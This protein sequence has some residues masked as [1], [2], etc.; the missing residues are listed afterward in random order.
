MRYGSCAEW[1]YGKQRRDRLR[2]RNI[3]APAL[4][5]V[6]LGTAAHVFAADS[7]Y[8]LAKSDFKRQ[9]Q[10]ISLSPLTV[11]DLLTVSAPMRQLIEAEAAK[12]LEKTRFESLDI[13]PYAALRDTLATQIGGLLD[14]AGNIDPRRQRVVWDHAKREM[15][16]RYPMDAFA[17][18]SL[19]V[20]GAPF[21]DNKAGVGRHPPQRA[22][23]R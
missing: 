10:V 16:L 13:A 20:V 1:R 12:Q 8:L 14:D 19:R 5:T 9:V 22:E 2:R 11:P 7:P 21:S 6:L 18:I 17:E 23:Q 15:R 3:G 4:L